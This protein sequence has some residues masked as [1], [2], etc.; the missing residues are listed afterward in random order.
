MDRL[1]LEG[2]RI[3]DFSWQIAGPTCTRYLGMMGA[4]VIRI[5]SERRPDPYRE[6]SISR[7]IN[8]SKKSITLNLSHARG[9]ELAQRV[10]GLSDVVIE[11]FAPGVIERLGLGYP[12][13]RRVKP[14]II[15]LSSAGLGHSGPDMK[16]VAYGTLIQCFTGWSALQGYPGHA[17]D[18]G[19]IWTD[20]VVGM[21]EVFLINAALHRCWQSGEGQYI[22][23]SM[24]EAT[25]MLLPEPMLDYSMNRR[26]PEPLGNQH[27]AYAPHGNYPCKGEDQWIGIAVAT[28]AQW[29]SLCQV[30]GLTELPADPRYADALRRWQNQDSL[31]R[32]LAAVT[33]RHD[34]LAL[35]VRLQQAGVPA[36]ASSSVDQ[37]WD[38]PQLR[39]RGFFQTYREQDGVMQ[40]LPATPWRLDG[41]AGG[42]MTA[43]PVRGEHNTYVFEELL[44]LSQPEVEALVEAQVIY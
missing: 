33:R 22:D 30:L 42:N 44:G 40:E 38:N 27:P 23:L 26:V 10:I 12:E 35:M 5:E 21:L 4:E 14:E 37:L 8:Q 1:P 25:T 31:D 2:V 43:Q 11:N 18:I 16:Q 7:F 3:A 29:Q 24:A 17:P 13:L 19:G 41:E 39:E 32:A 6:R 36:G 9:I 15:M 20:P 34:A 28:D